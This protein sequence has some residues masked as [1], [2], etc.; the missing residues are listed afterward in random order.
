M[1]VL[2]TTASSEQYHDRKDLSPLGGSTTH[3][4]AMPTVKM[5]EG[6]RMTRMM[7]GEMR[8]MR[9]SDCG[10]R[11]RSVCQLTLSGPGAGCTRKFRRDPL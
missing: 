4:D 11:Y 8:K 2:N 1:R 7:T 9:L 6:K 3:A 5:P 10:R